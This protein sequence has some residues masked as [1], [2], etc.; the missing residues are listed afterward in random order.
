MTPRPSSTPRATRKI[1]PLTRVMIS[2]VL[3]AFAVFTLVYRRSVPQATRAPST[4]AASN[5]P[6]PSGAP[7][8]EGATRFSWVPRFPGAQ[9]ENINTRRTREQISYGYSFHTATEFGEV[10]SFYGDQLQKAGFKVELKVDG[11]SGADKKAHENGG[12]LHADSPDGARSFD[13]LAAK[14]AS[15]SEI[16][17]TAI[18][19]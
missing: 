9:V 19:R 16:G 14:S 12:Q 5:K 8:S 6:F 11:S 15:G 13:V 2:A 1:S 3:L 10:L 7:S 17:V 4:A 18:E